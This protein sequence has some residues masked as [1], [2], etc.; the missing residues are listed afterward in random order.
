MARSEY[1]KKALIEQQRL[2]KEDMSD[3]DELMNDELMSNDGQSDDDGEPLLPRSTVKD[4]Q[5]VES[6][7]H[8]SSGEENNNN[9]VNPLIK[10]R[11]TID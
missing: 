1:K 5:D 11:K 9:F 2:L 10:S 7:G 3:E 4:G 8:S 6:E